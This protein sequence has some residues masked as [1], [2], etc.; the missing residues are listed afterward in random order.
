VTTLRHRVFG[1]LARAR[2]AR[3]ALSALFLLGLLGNGASPARSA[4]NDRAADA[5]LGQPDFFSAVA[6]NPIA[7]VGGLGPRSLNSP[8][9]A[10]IDA[11][12]G[13]LYVAD[14]FNNRVLSWPS[15]ASFQTADPADLVLGQAN[16]TSAVVNCGI[17]AGSPTPTGPTCLDGPEAVVV[18]SHSNVY[19][20]DTFNARVLM[21]PAPIVSGEAATVVFGQPD[22]THNGSGHGTG[23]VDALGFNGPQGVAIDAAGDVFVSDSGNNRV[24]EFS[25][26]YA[27]SGNAAVQVFGQS[28]FTSSLA[29]GGSYPSTS[30]AAPMGISVDASG[31]LL[32]ADSR[33]RRVV[34][35]PP[36]FATSAG[37]AGSVFLGG[38]YASLYGVGGLSAATF[39]LPVAVVRAA[40]G[41]IYVADGVNNRVLR[42]R[43]ASPGL[44][45]TA[46]AILGQPGPAGGTANLGGPFAGSLSAPR[47]LAVD[48]AGD[49]FVVDENN[50]RVLRLNQPSFT[51]CPALPSSGPAATAVLG[52]PDFVSPAANNAAAPIGGLSSRSLNAPGGVALDPTSGR[53]YASDTGNNRI[54]SWPSA[55]SFHNADPADIVLGQA[56][57]TANQ[58]NEGNPGSQPSATSLAS[59]GGLAVDGHGNLYVADTKNNRV[60]MYAA[61]ITS[62]EAAGLVFGQ[63]NLTSGVAN[64]GAGD[65]ST[66]ASVL[67]GPFA[68]A[69]DA[70]GNLYVADALNNRVLT[71]AAPLAS[72]E[73]ASRVFGQA[74][75]TGL[76][77]NAGGNGKPTAADLD[78]PFGVAVDA[79]GKVYVADEA[80][81]RVLGFTPPFTATAGLAA[82]F[83]LGEPDYTSGSSDL[84]AS[85]L[86]GPNAVLID[87]TGA[88]YVS[89]ASANR[90]VRFPK[91]T[92]GVGSVA[93]NVYGQP[94]F[95]S[96]V[97][98]A[99]GVTSASLDFPKAIAVDAAARLYVADAGNSRVLRFDQPAPTT[100]APS[101]NDTLADGVLGQ[102]DFANAA[103]NNPAAPVG[104]LGPRS[105]NA[106][107][108]VVIDPASRRLYV[109]D[110]GNNRVLSW[111]SA[112][113]FQ[114]A[115]PAD[116][117]LG[118]P[119]FTS[120]RSN[121]G[122][123]ASAT[124]LAGP[125]GLAVDLQGD[126]FASD[127]GNNR[128][129]MYP[130]PVTSGEAAAEVFGQSDFSQTAPNH[131]TG[132]VDAGTLDQPWGLAVD[133]AGDLFVADSRNNRV[134]AYQAPLTVTN[135][136]ATYVFGQA[137]DQTGDGNLGSGLPPGPNAPGLLGPAG[138]ALDASGDLFIADSGDNRV[139]EYVA[140]FPVVEDAAAFSAIL[141]GGTGPYLNELNDP[142]AV[143]VDPGGTAFI[144]DYANHRILPFQPPFSSSSAACGMI[145]QSIAD[146]SVLNTPSAVA[147]HGGLSSSSLAFP[148]GLA[149]DDAGNL[150]VADTANNRLLRYR[151]ALT[152]TCPA[153]PGAA[154][155]VTGAMST[156]REY[157]SATLLSNGQVLVAGGID[158]SLQPLAS[159]ELYNPATGQ[160]SLTGPMAAARYGHAAALLADGRVL[161]AGGCCDALGNLLTS[162]EIYDPTH[163]SWS[164]TGSL[165][166]PRFQSQ[167]ILLGNG[168]VLVAGGFGQASGTSAPTALA[169]IFNPATGAWAVENDGCSGAACSNSLGDYSSTLLNTGQVLLAGVSSTGMPSGQSLLD[170]PVSG[171]FTT[172]GALT[173]PRTQHTAIRLAD[174]SVLVAGGTSN[175][176]TRPVT[177]TTSVEIYEPGANEWTPTGALGQGRGNA[178]AV[179]LPNGEALV[180][181]GAGNLSTTSATAETYDPAT[182]T[183][184]GSFLNFGRANLT[185]T[186][187]PTG[188]VLAVGGCVQGSCP[189]SAEVYDPAVGGVPLSDNAPQIWTAPGSSGPVLPPIQPC[190]VCDDSGSLFGLN[191]SCSDSSGSTAPQA[192]LARLRMALPPSSARVLGA[193]ATTPA[194]S[195]STATSSA[196]N[197]ATLPND[198]RALRDAIMSKS[199]Q[200][201]YYTSLYVQYSPT[202]IQ[203]V[204]THPYVGYQMFS[205]L[206]EWQ[207]AIE[208]LVSGQGGSATISPQ[209]VS[210]LT[211]V[212]N[213]F[214]QLGSPSLATTIQLQEAALDLPSF[215][216]LPM[217]QALI[218][219]NQRISIL[220][221]P[222][223]YLPLVA[224]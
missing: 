142:L 197:L 164:A 78:F 182:K 202:L 9:S 58:A 150:F 221:T 120:N 115:D 107:G 62:T 26:P 100:C 12:S 73:A 59:P 51:D 216:N 219:A 129:L 29:N 64:N 133:R 153:P 161:V 131:G 220:P 176:T 180:A 90:V 17:S 25:P 141:G 69:V 48:P 214:A 179:L 157:H 140:P 31:E 211:D 96:D 60:L 191:S 188:Q 145:G 174:G 4:P 167:A 192:V 63:P 210:D 201:Q 40:T 67:N 39:D 28:D 49:L 18:D 156:S 37:P 137:G 3:L 56:S 207:P 125:L 183:W 66:N 162:A 97:A 84:S 23:N 208:A 154:W 215:V 136:L 114:N 65:G 92:V 19:V 144:A 113:S 44:G 74:S 181:G 146:P 169:E 158:N 175:P 222:Q 213:Q 21:Y 218:Q 75:F 159:A 155:T 212:L 184:S 86:D 83:V 128:V 57:F 199:P 30:L 34:I 152:P 190:V 98:D 71:Y 42:F 41:D 77:E 8:T 124:T 94:A 148:S 101:P 2:G 87:S 24:L 178:A 82:S 170:D 122:G 27:A 36:P 203:V 52:Q 165:V 116:L 103:A 195:R 6:N 160:F 53:F 143:A 106:P 54:L 168:N 186:L 138:I 119:D 7:P 198:L 14:W 105:L 91:P 11:V 109:A 117:V 111:P 61:P 81:N 112:A 1:F 22:F 70:T 20:A 187:L 130:A 108:G 89:D 193:A 72:S 173:T 223:I 88:V 127:A 13:R 38:T 43:S 47:G 194:L 171:A 166:E 104:G 132:S 35:Y 99:G 16:L 217:D 32:V 5:V 95:G 172:T 205:T 135:N 33:N 163:G 93:C 224:H 206:L 76:A 79:Q 10:A 80:N 134:L 151:H 200:G 102:P 196:G 123:A 189:V 185:L 118:Q 45:A 110:T 85:G 204:A 55:T 126:L 46:C 50:H 209:M 121:Q 147:N 177:Y 68:V 15:A 139:G 149:V